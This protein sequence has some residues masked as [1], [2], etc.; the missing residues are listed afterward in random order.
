MF[1]LCKE[2]IQSMIK[3]AIK[4]MESVPL[5]AKRYTTLKSPKYFDG[6]KWNGHWYIKPVTLEEI[7][8]EQKNEIDKLKAIVAELTDYV[9]KEN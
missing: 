1:G 9:Y 7:I 8:Q 5:R 4:N 6:S 2:E 3:E